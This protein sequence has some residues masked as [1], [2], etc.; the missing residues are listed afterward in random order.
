M[1]ETAVSHLNSLEYPQVVEYLRVAME[2]EGATYTSSHT[3]RATCKE[4]P[5]L[6]A[7][8]G[9]NREV[10]SIHGKKGKD[11]VLQVP[12]GTVVREMTSEPV[13]EPEDPFIHAPVWDKEQG[14]ED[15]QIEDLK[16]RRSTGFR[17]EK[18]PKE[19]HEI[20][21]D[22]RGLYLDLKKWTGEPI[23][24]LRGGRGGL[25]NMNFATQDI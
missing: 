20:E 11:V 9:Y 5:T 21:V 3:E 13:F 23:Q 12:I 14:T 17:R 8:N 22:E 25:G 2:V 7:D 18:P 16:K 15:W 1:A 4:S 10:S 6:A 19:L 24:I